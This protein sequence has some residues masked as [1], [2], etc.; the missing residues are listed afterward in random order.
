[1]S[2]IIFNEVDRFISAIHKVEGCEKT[3]IIRADSTFNME[4]STK[5]LNDPHSRWLPFMTVGTSM[6]IYI[7]DQWSCGMEIMFKVDSTILPDAHLF[8]E[9]LDETCVPEKC[10]PCK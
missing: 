7:P 10:C 4:I 6:D 3:I 9:I 1:M 5:S 8:V 2:K